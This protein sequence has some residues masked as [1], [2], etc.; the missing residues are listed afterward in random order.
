MI[1]ALFVILVMTVEML[2]EASFMCS[3][4]VPYRSAALLFFRVDMCFLTCFSVTVVGAMFSLSSCALR[5]WNFSSL[6]VLYSP[7]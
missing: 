6:E 7:S 3:A 5:R 2:L 1:R 4:V